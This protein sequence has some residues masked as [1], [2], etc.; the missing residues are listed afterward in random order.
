MRSN[1]SS[2]TSIIISPRHIF[3]GPT[4]T[5]KK[6]HP[7]MKE[8]ERLRLSATS[9]LLSRQ[10]V[11]VVAS[12][13]CI[14]GLGSPEELREPCPGQVYRGQQIS[15]ELFLAKLVDMLLRAKRYRSVAWEKFRARGDV[16]EVYPATSDEERQFESNSSETKSTKS[17]DSIRLPALPSPPG[18]IH[19]GFQRK[20]F[21]TPHTKKC[22]ARVQAIRI[23]FGRTCFLV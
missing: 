22:A 4:P 8:I 21:V 3:R 16:V 15:R 19:L 9:S 6:I 10:D 17:L 2:A 12:G 18:P 14:Y 20:Q 11:I 7:S 13:S 1:I 5:S 23:E